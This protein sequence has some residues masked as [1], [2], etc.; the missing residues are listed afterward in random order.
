MFHDK[1]RSTLIRTL[2]RGRDLQKHR[3]LVTTKQE[4]EVMLRRSE[5]AF[6]RSHDEGVA[7]IG[8]WRFDA[9][10]RFHAD[11][12]SAE[13]RKQ[14]LDLYCEL[15]GHGPFHYRAVA[16]E[17]IDVDTAL[18]SL[19]PYS[20][21]SLGT[22][23]THLMALGYWLQQL[24]VPHTAKL[25][26]FGSGCGDLAIDLAKCDF[27]VTAVDISSSY[28][29]V[30]RRR[31]DSERVKIDVI[32]SDMI[33]F[34]TSQVFDAAI[35]CEAFHHCDDHVAL[36]DLLDKILKPTSTI[37]F[38]GEPVTLFPSPWGVRL[39]GESLWA[40]RKHG[41]LELGFDSKYF[42]LMLERRGWS[43]TK[44]RNRAAGHRAYCLVAKRQGR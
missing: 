31:A 14:Q 34:K 42:R 16:Q 28:A 2:Y 11:P 10:R 43:L 19:Y 39:D 44:H 1:L 33:D 8:S 5:E 18:A 21:R 36:L 41:W 37:F 38:L 3:T 27:D 17:P 4:L 25:I 7:F 6:A 15:S 20:T 35:F 26:E 13:Y 23:G 29:D 9:G 30:L 40:A 12:E 32:V 24:T 22:T